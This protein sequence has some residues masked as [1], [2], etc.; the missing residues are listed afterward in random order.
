MKLKSLVAG[1]VQAAPGMAREE[2]GAEAIPV[3]SR[4]SPPE[5]R[6][7][8]EYEAVAASFPGDTTPAGPAPPGTRARRKA[9][10]LVLRWPPA[11]KTLVREVA[12]LRREVHLRMRKAL[13]RS[14]L[15]RVRRVP[16]TEVLPILLETGLEPQSGQEIAARVEALASGDLLLDAGTIP[17]PG[18]VLPSRDPGGEER[19]RQLLRAELERRFSVEPELSRPG[20]HSR[21]VSLAGPPGVGAGPASCL[22]RRPEIDTH[23][24]LQATTRFADLTSV[25]VRLE[26]FRPPRLLFTRVDETSSFDPAFSGMVRRAKPISLLTTGQQTP[27]DFEGGARARVIEPVL[28]R[29][30][31][32]G[33]FAAGNDYGR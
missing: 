30:S 24:T 32:Y 5:A 20:S 7:L 4:K 25:E 21:I 33:A 3:N 2:L 17:K 6:R 12:E 18:V 19:P 15:V 16:G 13:W 22:A 27:G 11:G 26:T 9:R 14:G 28:Q 31:D 10:G 23:L 1:P 29:N 8:G